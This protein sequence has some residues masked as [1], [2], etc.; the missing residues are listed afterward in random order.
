MYT[1]FI[2]PLIAFLANIILFSYTFIKGISNSTNRLFSYFTLALGIWAI[3]DALIFISETQSRALFYDP[4]PLIGACLTSVFLLHFSLSLT[5]NKLIEN[6]KFLILLYTPAISFITINF[7][8]NWINVSAELSWWGYNL[9]RGWLYIPY[10]LH[11]LLFVFTALLLIINQYNKT[12][13]LERKI[14]IKLLVIAI[15]IPFIAGILTQVIPYAIGITVIP[16]TSILTTFTALIIGYAILKHELIKTK[17]FSIYNKLVASFIIIL[18]LAM[19]VGGLAIIQ[20]RY[21]L[22]ESIGEGASIYAGQILN[23]IDDTITDR[24]AEFQYQTN[25]YNMDLHT[26]IKKSNEEF[27]SMG[28]NE[29]IFEYIYD[30]DEEWISSNNTTVFI[31]TLLNNNLSK[32]FNNLIDFYKES[33]NYTVFGEIFLT[34]RYGANIGLSQ[35]TTDYYQADEEW[36]LKTREYGKY[37]GEIEYDASS[38]LYSTSICI[39]IDDSDGNFIGILKAVWNIQ[40]IINL[41][42]I[43]LFSSSHGYYTNYTAHLLNTQGSLIYST[44]EFEF[45]E[46]RS[47]WLALFQEKEERSF[48]IIYDN[49]YDKEQKLVAYAFSTIQE[50][51]TDNKWLLI[52][53]YN[54]DQIL[55]PIYE[56]RDLIILSTI[57]ITINGLFISYILSRTISKPLI[58]LRDATEKI[59][60][61]KLDTS[62]VI[63]SN[64]EIGELSE[65]FQKMMM[66]LKNSRDELEKY[67]RDLENKVI[68]RTSELVESKKEIERKNIGLKLAH[69]KLMEINIQLEG[70]VAERTEQIQKLLKQKDEFIYQLG[71]DLKNPLG[72]LISLLPLLEKHI[73]TEKDREIIKVLIRNVHYMKNLVAK[74]LELAKLNSPN[75][76]LNIESFRLDDEL[77]NII[78]Q[79]EYFLNQKNITVINNITE[80]M[81]VNADKLRFQELFTNLINNAVKYSTEKG[82][83]TIEAQEKD[84]NI[85]FS[86]KDDG[87]GMTPDQLEQL[88]DEFYKADKSRHD[89]DSSGLGMTITKR[90]IEMHGGQI[91]AE[92]NGLGK[93]STFHFTLPIDK[94]DKKK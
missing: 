56:L 4:I 25:S 79:N 67:N 58:K 28:S 15:L 12:T 11:L 66:E 86:I 55:I 91:W 26:L 6:K 62:L 20:S 27:Q 19:V 46:D 73:E 2:Y 36:W 74:T 18:L 16:M 49:K 82:R 92:S 93:G 40:E 34:N 43:S 84:N 48:F 5:E 44:N 59:S 1:Y 71:H 75:T 69:D 42:N 21:I 87:I 24:I 38:D 9:V 81:Y 45:L 50:Q 61:G 31:D 22:E 94:V 65:S 76:T 13:S 17:F 37:F 3:G 32:K 63:N 35:K 47:E 70:R 33:Y 51:I 41:L 89:F 64:D 39:R 7:T 85:F 80:D 53:D 10:S 8:T 90:I 88:F 78:S 83:I 29:E 54:T 68:Q 77:N 14:Q 52:I 30:K 57:L 60:K 72:P 23:Q